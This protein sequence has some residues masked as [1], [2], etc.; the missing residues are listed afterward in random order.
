MYRRKI[1]CIEASIVLISIT[2]MIVMGFIKFIGTIESYIGWEKI[3]GVLFLVLLTVGSLFYLFDSFS[4]L[5]K[6]EYNRQVLNYLLG[7]FILGLLALIFWSLFTVFPNGI[8]NNLIK[9]A[10]V[11]VFISLIRNK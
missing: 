11:L 2:Y 6:G 3:L 9:I 7:I 10:L 1:G 5:F 4:K 8:L